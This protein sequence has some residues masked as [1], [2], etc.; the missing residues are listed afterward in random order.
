MKDISVNSSQVRYYWRNTT[1]ERFNSSS[2][3]CQF[4]LGK[5]LLLKK[6]Q[7]RFQ[8]SVN[9][10]Q[11]RYYGNAYESKNSRRCM[12]SG[13]NSSQVRYYFQQS[14]RFCFRKTCVNSSQVRYYNGGKK[15][16]QKELKETFCV[17]S[18]QVRY[19]YLPT[20]VILSLCYIYY[21][22]SVN[23]SQVR[24]YNCK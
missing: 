13:V 22:G 14:W 1:Y 3:R 9:S 7:F 20:Y 10:S 8:K 19:Y 5:V 12:G 15:E 16:C 11:V 18:S 2:R 6:G 17:N 21:L 23:S 4:L 24:Y